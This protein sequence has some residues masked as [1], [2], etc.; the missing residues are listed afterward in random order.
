MEAAKK[1]EKEKV[2]EKLVGPVFQGAW[3]LDVELQSSKETFKLVQMLRATGTAFPKAIDV[4]LPFIRAED[5]RGHTSVFSLAEASDELYASAPDK[6]LDL[7][8]AVVGDAPP[9]SIFS[10]RKALEKLRLVAPQL[11]QTKR[12]QKLEI[13]AGVY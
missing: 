4:V 2:W 6:M 5:P 7:L 9:Q 3:P 8:S 1:E 10:L 11:V 13:Q 12:F